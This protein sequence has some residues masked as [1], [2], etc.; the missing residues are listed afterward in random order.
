MTFRLEYFDYPSWPSLAWVAILKPGSNQIIV[1]CG[2][3][4]ERNQRWFCEAVWDDQFGRGNFD[5][6]DIVAGS[7]GRCR[8]KQ[9]TFVSSGS[10][11]DRLN[12]MTID[13]IT[14]VSNSLSAL[15]A[16]TGAKV[17]PTET[18]YAQIF[19]S[20]T[21][22]LDNYVDCLVTSRGDIGF[23]YFENLLW[24]G[25]Q[26]YMQPK[27]RFQ[28]DF[29]TYEKYVEFLQVS[30][31]KVISNALD[32]SRRSPIKPWVTLSNGYDSPTVAVLA[33][34]AGVQDAITLG[35]DRDGN[36]DSGLQIG[37]RLGYRT[38]VIDRQAWRQL[39]CPEVDCI[40]A[41]G[42][43]A[44]VAFSAMSDQLQGGLLLTGFWGGA[45]WKK[46]R[47]DLRPIFFGHDGSGLCLTETRLSA[48]FVHCS[49]PFWGGL[50][51]ADIVR[52]SR[53]DALT[54]WNV[55]GHYNR[56]IC[57]RVVETAGIRREWF[58]QQ[59]HGASEHVFGAANFL[60]E[61]STRDYD[62]WMRGHSSAWVTKWRIP[63]HPVL[64][65]I[66]DRLLISITIPVLRRIVIP[67]VRKISL[68]PGG[69]RVEHWVVKMRQILMTLTNAPLYY[70]RY[71][72]PWAL[73]RSTKK[74][75]LA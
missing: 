1:R 55:P 69:V 70:R 49:I 54:E 32:G 10:L 66:F 47:R 45:V 58:G 63:A 4:V 28:R 46:E 43:A 24:D 64:G 40:A 37:R 74:Y 13:G 22:G 27:R 38:R 7:G 52:I 34:N 14:L 71:T 41:S 21:C 53:S 61:G 5:R 30:M 44:E 11:L 50:Q 36:D 3:N 19:G 6:T 25:E 39:D 15:A 20:I 65:K 23:V 51:I 9:L 33:A 31:H 60:S 48:G 18:T 29:S 59:K 72:F 26:I 16:E 12:Y 17:D 2:V 8:G 62:E 75:F 73:S 42:T 68:L 56:P 35:H 57:R 67:I